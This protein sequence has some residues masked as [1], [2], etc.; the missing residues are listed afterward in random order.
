MRIV[1]I[2]SATVVRPEQVPVQFE[3]TCR[4]SR[5][6]FIAAHTNYRLLGFLGYRQC[7]MPNAFRSVPRSILASAAS[8]R[9]VPREV[10]MRWRLLSP[11][12]HIGS[13][14]GAKEQVKAVDWTQSGRWLSRDT[15]PGLKLAA[16]LQ[17]AVLTLDNAWPD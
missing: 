5:D 15:K 9:E 10:K 11:R 14:T 8:T 1:W 6:L 4:R 3:A 12:A 17:L 7:Q 2:S 16:C 13:G